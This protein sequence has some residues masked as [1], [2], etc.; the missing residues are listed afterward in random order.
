MSPEIGDIV[1]ENQNKNLHIQLP[2][3]LLEIY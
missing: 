2:D 1:K 3:L